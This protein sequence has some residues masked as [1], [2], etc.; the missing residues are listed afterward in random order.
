MAV[1]AQLVLAGQIVLAAIYLA[2]AHALAIETPNIS[3]R[4]RIEAHSSG[5]ATVTAGIKSIWMDFFK[6]RDLSNDFSSAIT[7][8]DFCMV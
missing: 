1:Q 7:I 6:S 4:I 5:P 2:K 3:I 8:P